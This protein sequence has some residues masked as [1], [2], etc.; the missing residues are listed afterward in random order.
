ML[1][2]KF[3]KEKCKTSFCHPIKL[4]QPSEQARLSWLEEL[5]FHPVLFYSLA[6]IISDLTIAEI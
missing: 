4:Q 2:A 6:F 1:A 3:K 5:C